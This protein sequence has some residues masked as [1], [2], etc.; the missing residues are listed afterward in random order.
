MV[1][2]KLSVVF[3]NGEGGF[4]VVL[5]WGRLWV[6]RWFLACLW[7]GLV[8]VVGVVVC[9]VWFGG[10]GCLRVDFGGNVCGVVRF[11]R[12][13]WLEMWLVGAC[14]C[15]LAVCL[16]WSLC[17]FVLCLVFGCVCVGLAW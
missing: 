17:V 4:T 5:L 9:V 14:L 12:D 8:L 7:A 2:I 11:V 10:C 15:R 1:W 13:D 6:L 16:F 3:G